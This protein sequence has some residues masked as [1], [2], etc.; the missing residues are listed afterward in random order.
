LQ[1]RALKQ[2]KKSFFD[3]NNLFLAIVTV[4]QECLLQ[5]EQIDHSVDPFVKEEV[6]G[7]HLIS[8]A[9]QL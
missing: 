6:T 8:S 4:V 1:S 2:S 5:N 9:M 7:K 3:K